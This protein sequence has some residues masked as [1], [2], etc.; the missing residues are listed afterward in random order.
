M[1]LLVELLLLSILFVKAFTWDQ[2]QGLNCYQGKGAEKIY[3]YPFAKDLSL[4]ECRAACEADNV[5]EGIVVEN[6][7]ETSGKC[8]KVKNVQLSKCVTQNKY[9]FNMKSEGIL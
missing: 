1:E 9:N 6:G 7:K 3:P 2:H 8:W 5:C 4:S